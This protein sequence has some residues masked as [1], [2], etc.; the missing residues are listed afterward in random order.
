[1]TAAV[2]RRPR[3]LSPREL[4]VVRAVARGLTDAEVAAELFV[5]PSTVKTHLTHVRA[6]LAARNRVEVAAWVWERGLLR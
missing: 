2:A 1:V 3:P 6:K 5:S 4:D